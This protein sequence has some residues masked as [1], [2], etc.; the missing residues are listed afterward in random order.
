M[1]SHEYSPQEALRFLLRKIEEKDADLANA[2]Q[3]AIDAG[4]DVWESEVP[5]IR[6]KRRKYRKTVRFSDEEALR[7]AISIFEAHFI[8]QPLFANS[9]IDE[10]SDASLD[11][12]ANSRQE[13]FEQPQAESTERGLLEKRLAVEFQMETQISPADKQPVRL[14]RTEK[15]TIAQQQANIR[16]LSKL[17]A[18]DEK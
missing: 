3:A 18:F 16:R 8:E 17:V 1:P 10:L 5:A 13:S 14:L 12:V 7:I 6:K 4:K 15:E 2:L 9:A 11:V